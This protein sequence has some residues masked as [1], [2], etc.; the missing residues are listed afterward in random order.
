MAAMHQEGARAPDIRAGRVFILCNESAGGVT[1]G[2]SARLEGALLHRF[3]CAD[4][5]ELTLSDGPLDFSDLG[6]DDLCIVL[7]GDGTA[8]AA[9][10][11]ASGEDGPI[12]VLLPGGTLNVLPHALYGERPWP[13]ALEAALTRGEVRRLGGAAANG[14]P[15]FVAA[16][17]GAPALLAR[18]R[19]AI[20]KGQ[21][22]SALRKLRHFIMRALMRRLRARADAGPPQKAE[23]IGVL[24]PSFAGR[25]EGDDLEWVRFDAR[26]VHDFISLGWR[27][28]TSSWRNDRSIDIQRC[29]GGDIVG[30][31]L[32]PAILD[33]EPHAFHGRIRIEKLRDGP[34]VLA[35]PNP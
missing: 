10:A 29:E 30:R 35:L 27:T 28:L 25:L 31:R 18:A 22:F 8:N 14:K 7:G 21:F 6:P 11:A 5:H 23:A 1:A 9:A 2:D 13:E 34:K 33:G 26:S 4:V 19:E 16:V 24:C 20:R 17:F 15:F 3:G 12:L 32:I